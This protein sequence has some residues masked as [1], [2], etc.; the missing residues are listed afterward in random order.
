MSTNNFLMQGGAMK[1]KSLFFFFAIVFVGTGFTFSE[2]AQ[3]GHYE[4]I[5]GKGVE[6][7]EA[8]AKNLNSFK[9]GIPMICERQ[10]N[11]EMK[12]FSR[13]TWTEIDPWQNREMVKNVESFLGDYPRGNPKDDLAQWEDGVKDR[14][15]IHHLKIE[16]AQ[17]DI[18]N[19]G[20]NENTI[21]YY[22]GSCP[23]TRHYGTPLLVIDQEKNSIE[24]RTALLMQNPKSAAGGTARG[25]WAGTM[26]DVFI[27][28]DIVYFDRWSQS[29]NQTGL[30]KVF[31]TKKDMTKEACRYRFIR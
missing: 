18:D 17:V 1:Q 26:Y 14:V 21:K 13:P 10:I 15:K 28:K 5:K 22:D 11:P 27:Y 30:L 29:K 7:C 9:P 16:L 6:V 4:L 2:A 31:T 19:D 25:I 12:D 23:M 24:K 20:K 3:A 8:Y